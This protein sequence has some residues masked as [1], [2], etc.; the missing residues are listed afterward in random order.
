MPVLRVVA[1]ADVPRG[2]TKPQM[3]PSVRRCRAQLAALRPELRLIYAAATPASAA[4]ILRPG[5]GRKSRAAD[6][7]RRLNVVA[8][9]AFPQSRMEVAADGASGTTSAL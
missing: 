9:H 3:D 5:E 6:T 8:V 2:S 7:G 1:A 4:G